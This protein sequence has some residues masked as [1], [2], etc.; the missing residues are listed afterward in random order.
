MFKKE[1]CIGEVLVG[2]IV[3]RSISRIA[4][5]YIDRM[6]KEDTELPPK[7]FHYMLINGKKLEEAVMPKL[8]QVN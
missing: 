7:Q 5:P 2:K 8:Y 1:Q 4:K 3:D 6:M